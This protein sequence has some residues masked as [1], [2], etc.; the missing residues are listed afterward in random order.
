MDD[1]YSWIWAILRPNVGYTHFGRGRGPTNWS[2]GL[3]AI[4]AQAAPIKGRHPLRLYTHTIRCNA[5]MPLICREGGEDAVGEKIHNV[6]RRFQH[7]IEIL[8]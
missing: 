3:R 5:F 2:I 1:S 6:G 8:I 7:Q 4:D